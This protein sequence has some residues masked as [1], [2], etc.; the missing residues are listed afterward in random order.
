VNP[1]FEKAIQK[2]INF[3]EEAETIVKLE[4]RRS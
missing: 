2:D 3:K 1:F 4:K